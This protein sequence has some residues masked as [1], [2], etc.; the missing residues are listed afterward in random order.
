[1][2]GDSWVDIEAGKRAGTG[3]IR[4]TYGLNTDRTPDG[5]AHAPKKIL[6]F[7]L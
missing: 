3:T 6:K 7:F 4:V 2:V 1:M 5:I